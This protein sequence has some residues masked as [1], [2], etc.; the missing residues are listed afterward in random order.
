M[1]NFFK[2]LKENRNGYEIS[3]LFPYAIYYDMLHQFMIQ[4]KSKET[5]KS[6]LKGIK[7]FAV[8]LQKQ[9][10]VSEAFNQYEYP[11][12]NPQNQILCHAIT[13]NAMFNVFMKYVKNGFDDILLSDIQQ[14]NTNGRT[15]IDF[16]TY[17]KLPKKYRGIFVKYDNDNYVLNVP[18]KGMVF[19]YNKKNKLKLEQL[20]KRA[21]VLLPVIYKE[22]SPDV[23]F[24]G[25]LQLFDGPAFVQNNTK[26]AYLVTSE[27]L[28]TVIELHD[29]FVEIAKITLPFTTVP[30]PQHNAYDILNEYIKS[31]RQIN[32]V[33]DAN[34]SYKKAK[35]EIQNSENTIPTKIAHGKDVIQTKEIKH[36]LKTPKNGQYRLFTK[37]Q[38]YK[39]AHQIILNNLRK[40]LKNYT[41]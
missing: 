11:H 23:N 32:V 39:F 24:G 1:K 22:P 2:T 41:R 18:F 34:E 35:K 31:Q 16:V 7:S 4:S 29:I 33:V 10:F 40:T 30:S 36:V 6:Y 15:I 9:P 13:Y 26:S 14:K 8:V 20:L 12:R 19:A 25:V 38:E 3:N 17:N 21:Q 27:Q 5:K 37:E 28:K